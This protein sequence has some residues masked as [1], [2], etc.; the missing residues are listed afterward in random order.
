[1]RTS[2]C[3]SEQIVKNPVREVQGMENVL[4]VLRE[5]NRR[6]REIEKEYK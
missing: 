4:R 6:K 2:R 5:K 1:M 3:G